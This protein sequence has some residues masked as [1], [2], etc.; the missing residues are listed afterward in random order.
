MRLCCALS[1][2]LVSALVIPGVC[3]AQDGKLPLKPK[4]PI[5]KPPT[6]K[7]IDLGGRGF[8]VESVKLVESSTACAWS[9]E[10]TV[11]N[12]GM[13]AFTGTFGLRTFLVEGV[14]QETVGSN[15]L[16]VTNVGAGKTHT[17]I[18]PIL[19]PPSPK[20]DHLTVTLTLESK[21]VDTKSIA[22]GLHYTALI[23]SA[24]VEAGMVRVAVKSTS[25]ASAPLHF[26]VFKSVPSAQGGWVSL[27]GRGLCVAPGQT[28]TE[29]VAAPPGWPNDPATLK[30]VLK[31]GSEVLGEKLITA[32]AH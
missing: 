4:G 9:Y 18:K 20:Y 6:V 31:S 10:I 5:E 12:H 13:K 28:V 17:E 29:A 32:P 21:E 7:T 30:V 14:N 23:E 16:H 19:V 26:T 3:L 22:L 25:S 11:R 15:V 24:R 27:G 8:T 2:F 1:W